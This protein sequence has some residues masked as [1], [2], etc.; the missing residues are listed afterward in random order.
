LLSGSLTASRD[1]RLD[2]VRSYPLP[3]HVGAG[4]FVV[5]A[6]VVLFGS[7]VQGTIGFGLN[8]LAAPFIALVL[9]EALPVT[10][11]LVAWPVGGVAA[12][13][14]H[15]ALDRRALPWLLAGAVPGTLVGLAIVTQA[16]ADELAIIVGAVTV[17]GVA[18]S[19]VSPPI[20]VGP[21]SAGLAGFVSNITGTAAAV[22]GPPVALLYQHHGG[23]TV[24]ATLGVFF[25]TSATLSIAGYAL[26]GEITEDRVLLALALVPAMLAG[27]WASKHFHNLV[28]TRWL[29]PA[30]LTMCAIAGT[31]AIL[32][33][34]L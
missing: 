25:A 13:R 14:E 12:L 22:G 11:V 7:L 8:L 30:V 21:G 5:A 15:H 2:A 19:V 20:H 33:G 4:E 24:R 6:L 9:P 31:A 3:V 34:A 16:S 32:R 26:T 28:D 23:P 29:R 18:A 10:L 27:L 1:T 17:L